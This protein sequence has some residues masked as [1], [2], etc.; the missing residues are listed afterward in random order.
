MLA[1]AMTQSYLQSKFL[2]L[3]Q[4]IELTLKKTVPINKDIKIS[5]NP[6]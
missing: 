3:I 4:P 1:S 5:N 2:E 6:K